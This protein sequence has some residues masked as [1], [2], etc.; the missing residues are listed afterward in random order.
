MKKKK[1]EENEN[2]KNIDSNETDEEFEKRMDEIMNFMSM[3]DEELN[4]LEDFLNM[5][6][7]EY[8]LEEEETNNEA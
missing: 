4:K 3:Q 6:K 2:N 7:A 1:I 8:G 5:L